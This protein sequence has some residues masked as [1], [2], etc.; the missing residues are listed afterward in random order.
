VLTQLRD[1]LAAD[2]ALCLRLTGRTDATGTPAVNIPLSQR[3]AESVRQWLVANGIP[4]ERLAA[5]G[6]G[7]N[8]P[9][10]DSASESGRALN[11]RVQAVKL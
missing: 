11:R 4:A 7:S 2:P 6:R 3:R 1:A 9:V 5:E 10:A 8:E